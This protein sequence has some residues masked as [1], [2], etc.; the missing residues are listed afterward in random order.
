[1][2]D[3]SSDEW[4]QL[5]IE[6]APTSNA[7]VQLDQWEDA[8]E[9]IGALSITYRDAEDNPVFEPGPGEIA[10][11]DSLKLTALFA[12]G[13]ASA[14]ILRELSARIQSMDVTAVQIEMLPDRH[15][16]RAWLD[17]FAPMPFG[18]RLWICPREAEPPNAEAVNLRLDPGLAFGTGTHPTTAM[19]LRWLDANIE[20]G[21]DVIDYG[22][23]S[24]V[25]GIAA[26]L[27]GAK[28][29][30]ATDIDP[31]A[32]QATAE[33]ARVN[34]VESALECVSIET[35]AGRTANLVLANILARPL[36][37]LAATIT[38]HCAPGGRIVL[39]GLL[40]EQEADVRRAYEGAFTDWQ[41]Q[42]DAQWVC[43]S[44]SRIE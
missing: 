3:T 10:L 20:Q 4:L 21:A 22:C 30:V 41:R 28:H 39:A 24:G 18:D 40:V 1:M 16:E 26:L 15:W 2:S 7:S 9:D 6:L 5:T 44:A 43:L 37:D 11:W 14:P 36:V 27:L 19:C 32:L 12:Q 34:Q 38:G 31:Q 35:M 42:T 23:G 13:S 33:N 25:L 17:D 8:L 29:V